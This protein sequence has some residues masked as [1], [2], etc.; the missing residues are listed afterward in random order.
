[1]DRWAKLET[2]RFRHNVHPR[3]DAA[4]FVELCEF[5]KE[6][7]KMIFDQSM[8]VIYFMATLAIDAYKLLLKDFSNKL[9]EKGADSM[10]ITEMVSK[11]ILFYE[12]DVIKD[13]KLKEANNLINT[14][15]IK[16]LKSRNAAQQKWLGAKGGNISKRGGD[17]TFC[18][19]K[20]H[21]QDS[22]YA[23]PKSGSYRAKGASNQRSGNK[24]YLQKSATIGDCTFC[25]KKGHT[26][27]ICKMKLHCNKCHKKGHLEADCTSQ[28]CTTCNK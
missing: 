14:K 4:T 7:K 13:N 1:M 8:F 25:G 21:T 5:L 16:K 27:N 18:G 9:D 15:E 2:F 24:I 19:K 12:T 6:S 23:N 10:S 3:N 20:G 11:T 17:C 28:A 26:A 22:C